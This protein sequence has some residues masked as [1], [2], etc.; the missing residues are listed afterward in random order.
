MLDLDRLAPEVTALNT[1]KPRVA[2]LYS[3]PS[4]FWEEQYPGTLRSLYTVLNFM[5]ENVTF[6]SE[7]QLAE[8]KAPKV[9]WLLVPNAT[10][11]LPST[12]AAVAA[13]A[14]SGGQGPAGRQGKPPARRIRP[15]A[16]SGHGLSDDGIGGRRAGDRRRPAPEA[17]AAAT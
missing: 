12:P 10:H 13:F 9:Q 11:V 16:E 2:L 17:G 15:A 4:L 1:A 3:Q 14:K 8:G 7:R 5:G 6:V